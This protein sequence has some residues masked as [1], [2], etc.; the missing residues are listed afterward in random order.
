MGNAPVKRGTSGYN[1]GVWLIIV[2][3]TK[4]QIPHCQLLMGNAPVKEV[5]FGNK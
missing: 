4:T 3:M 2:E 5:T 1:R